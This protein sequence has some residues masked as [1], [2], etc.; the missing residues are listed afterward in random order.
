M[1]QYKKLKKRQKTI[2]IK[3]K[4]CY[5]FIKV[6]IPNNFL[7]IKKSKII[8]F[9]PDLENLFGGGGIKEEKYDFF[10]CST[11]ILYVVCFNIC[12][13]IGLC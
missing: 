10:V 1:C 5:I 4:K 3:I 11:N 6:E 2:V 8:Y 12:S 13:A 9:S 7:F